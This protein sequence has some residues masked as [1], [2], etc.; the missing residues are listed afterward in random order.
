MVSDHEVIVV[1]VQYRMSNLGWFRHPALRQESSTLEDASG[2]FGTLDNIISR[3]TAGK[4]LSSITNIFS[5]LNG[6]LYNAV[7]MVG[8][9]LGVLLIKKFY[10]GQQEL[11]KTQKLQK[12]LQTQFC[13]VL[14]SFYV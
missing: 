13:T 8:F 4:S 2:S 3:L 12:L 6:G 9:P 1:T 14:V 7:E 11:L 10:E 5:Y